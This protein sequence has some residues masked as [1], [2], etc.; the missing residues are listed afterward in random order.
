MLRSTLIFM[1]GLI[2]GISIFYVSI[3]FPAGREISKTF[4]T[5]FLTREKSIIGFLPYWLVK[6]DSPDYTKSLN[7]VDYF[8]V[9]LNIDGSI[10]KF[11]KPGETE[12]GW[13]KLKSDAVEGVLESFRKKNLKRSLVV[14]SGDQEVIDRLMDDPIQH[15]K[16]LAGDISPLID[17]YNF[18]GINLDVEKVSTA[19]ESSRQKFTDF[20]KEFRNQIIQLDPSLALSIDVSPTALLK[21]YLIDVR[22]IAPYVDEVIFMT[23]D[24]HFPGSSVSGPVAPIYGA[25]TVSEYDTETAIK[26]ALRILPPEKIIIGIPLYGYEWETLN[27]Y[28]RAAVIPGTGK[29]ASNRR[30]EELLASCASCSAEFDETDQEAHIIYKNPDTAAYH[31]IFYP[32]KRAMKA[33]VDLINKYNIGGLALWALGYEGDTILEPLRELK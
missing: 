7:E 1:L 10:R 28:P 8:A 22:A 6:D 14:F 23:Y 20:T 17:E 16:N 31:Q 24:Y 19:S 2:I 26:E 27:G 30:A 33:K 15:A 21:P 5:S 12:P 25:G 9:D 32:D 4:K 13:L 18:S 3:E 29:T 11:V